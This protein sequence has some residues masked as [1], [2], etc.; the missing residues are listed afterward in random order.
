MSVDLPAPFSPTMPWIVPAAID[1]VDVAV[2]VDRAEALVD[3]DEVERGRRHGDAPGSAPGR[4]TARRGAGERL[5][6]LGRIS[7]GSRCRP[8]SRGR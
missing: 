7:S 5:I 2:G 3:A 4:G 6:G 1:E 8:C